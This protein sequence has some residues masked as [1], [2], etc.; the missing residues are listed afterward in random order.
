MCRRDCPMNAISSRRLNPEEKE[1]GQVYAETVLELAQ[2]DAR[3][4]ALEA[5]LMSSIST[6]KI[7]PVIPKQII[8]CGIM[9]AHM[10]S[11]AAGIALTGNIP[12]VYAITE[13]ATRTE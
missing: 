1:M 11:V 7:Q 3:V 10:M 12:V 13:V 5:D 9:E 8:N 2:K 4:I 6:N